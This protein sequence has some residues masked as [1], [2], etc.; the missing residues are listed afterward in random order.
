[1]CP[2][3]QGAGAVFVLFSLYPQHLQG[4]PQTFAPS[5]EPL[6][7]H[8]AFCVPGTLFWHL[9]MNLPKN[10]PLSKQ[11]YF[12]MELLESKGTFESSRVILHGL[13]LWNVRVN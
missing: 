3:L 1:M 4:D 12:Q 6:S 2:G 5:S 9:S 8:S 13:Q 10:E 11:V 7:S